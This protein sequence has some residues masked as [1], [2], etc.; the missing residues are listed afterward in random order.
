LAEL[1]R[2]FERVVLRELRT[3]AE[4]EDHLCHRARG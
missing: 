1:L 3:V 2:Q 4:R